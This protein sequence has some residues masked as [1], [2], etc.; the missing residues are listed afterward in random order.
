M[1]FG[2]N[3]PF[4]V[5]CSLILLTLSFT[6]RF[7][8]V[9][10][11]SLPIISF[12]DSVFDVIYK[13]ASPHPRTFRFSPVLSYRSFIVLCFALRSVVYFELIF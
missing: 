9:I 8:I 12:M 5:A 6:D 2:N 11:L 3:F 4:G 13:K 7:L 10:K 1:S